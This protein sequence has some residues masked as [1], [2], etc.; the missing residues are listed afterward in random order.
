M[1]ATA[2]LTENKSYHNAK[3]DGEAQKRSI[4]QAGYLA[5]SDVELGSELW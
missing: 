4:R 2:S 5:D 1:E 3:I